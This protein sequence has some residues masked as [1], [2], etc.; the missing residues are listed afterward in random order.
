MVTLNRPQGYTQQEEQRRRIN[1]S[2]LSCH[3]LDL[4]SV[5]VVFLHAS[6]LW[7]GAGHEQILAPP[8]STWLVRVT[9]ALRHHLRTSMIRYLTGELTCEIGLWRLVPQTQS[10]LPRSLQRG[11]CLLNWAER[12][13][14]KIRREGYRK[15]GGISLTVGDKARSKI[16]L[17]T[18]EGR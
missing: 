5:P 16:M 8:H 12:M 18:D 3:L 15:K 10:A 6:A 11:P 4:H 13:E 2:Q 7:R 17:Y 9:T 14:M 1:K